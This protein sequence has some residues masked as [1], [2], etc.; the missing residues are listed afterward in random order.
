[1]T[2][3][4]ITSLASGLEFPARS[5]DG[6]AIASLSGELDVA[7]TPV[8]RE[9]LLGLL[10][11]RASRLVIDLS[12]V[13]FCDASGLAVLVGTGRRARLLG[14]VLRL[15]APAPAVASA[16][17]LSGLL[18]QF[19]VFP[20]VVAAIARPRA[21]KRLP[22]ASTQA[23]TSGAAGSDGLATH[24]T[25][26]RAPG[27]PRPVTWV[28]RSLNCWLTPTHG[29]MRTPPAGSQASCGRWRGLR[30]AAIRQR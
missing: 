20:A 23:G 5:E 1:M 11:L 21:G 27:V 25:R 17:R 2:L 7:C 24:L 22:D 12:E 4:D 6:Y 13:S 16:L 9:Q 30:P 29:A 3:L 15:A 18:R 8:L 10:R 28:K 19:D 26:T 14:G